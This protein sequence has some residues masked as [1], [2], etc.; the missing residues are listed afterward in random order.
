LTNEAQEQAKKIMNPRH[1]KSAWH[2]VTN[3]GRTAFGITL[4]ASTALYAA[5]KI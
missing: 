3:A 2:T 4:D 5:T 1:T